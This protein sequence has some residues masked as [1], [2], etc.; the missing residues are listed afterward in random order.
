MLIHVSAQ[1]LQRNWDR[2]AGVADGTLDRFAPGWR[3]IV[4]LGQ[5]PAATRAAYVAYWA[6]KVEALGFPRPERPDLVT[7]SRNQRLYWLMF[8]G[9]EFARGLWEKIR[10]VSDQG[11][12][13][14]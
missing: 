4:D 5:S 6:G 9:N 1:D 2:Y 3:E 13:P 7:G 10:N 8:V 12:L 11:E 14:I